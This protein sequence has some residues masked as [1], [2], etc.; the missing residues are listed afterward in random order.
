MGPDSS[1]EVE[2]V[3]PAPE[4]DVP[5]PD[6][7]AF[8]PSLVMPLVL[9][10]GGSEVTPTSSSPSPGEL[11]VMVAKQASASIRRPG[12]R[13]IVITASPTGGHTT[14]AVPGD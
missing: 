4:L 2:P 7:P 1:A 14:Q 6:E 12:V 9:G 13:S 10:R 5:T 8:V 3:V 11:Q